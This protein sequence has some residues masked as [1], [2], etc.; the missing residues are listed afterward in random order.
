MPMLMESTGAPTGWPPAGMPSPTAPVGSKGAKNMS[1]RFAAAL[2]G[3]FAA[4]GW[5]LGQAP[6]GAGPVA[7]PGVTAPAPPTSAIWP[8]P[9]PGQGPVGSGPVAGPGVTAPAPPPSA[10]WPYPYG[11]MIPPPN[12]AAPLTFSSSTAPPREP[13]LIDGDGDCPAWRTWVSAEYLL[14]FFKSAP[15]PPNLI[16]RG[17]PLDLQPGALGQ[18]GTSVLTD[19]RSVDFGPFSGGRL[20]AGFWLD[21]DQTIGLEA[22]GFLTQ[23]QMNTY[24]EHS[25]P[26]GLPVLAFP[27]LNADGSQGAFV[28]S[29]PGLIGQPSIGSVGYAAA[30]QLWG[31]EGN[32]VSRIYRDP[33]LRV[34]CLAGFRYL[35]LSEKLDLDFERHPIGGGAT[36]YLGFPVVDPEAVSVVDSFHTRNQFYGGQVGLSADYRWSQFVFSLGGKVAVGDTHESVN[37]AGVSNLQLGTATLATT[38]AGHFALATNSGRRTQ[39]QFGIVPEVQ[40]K[41]GYQILRNLSGFIGYDFLYWNQV[42]RPG[43]QVDQTVDTRQVP[44]SS[45]YGGFPFPKITAPEALFNR[46]D[47]WAQGLT[48]GMEL[49]Y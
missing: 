11:P 6:C 28:A 18:P 37:I 39:D 47:F 32:L 3:L 9:S 14:F 23:T 36:S 30:S 34:Q 40:F 16:T 33:H 48:F 26:L 17:S 12:P 29:N 5:A 42:V 43:S 13:N 45:A 15:L 22:I 49:T 19:N 27:H 35:D 2:A 21:P 8:Y 46:T 7:G 1:H 24:R 31:S 10:I 38:D 41:I 20:S 44:T 25:G 4:G